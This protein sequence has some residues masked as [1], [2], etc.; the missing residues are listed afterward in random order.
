MGP[1][2]F[3]PYLSLAVRASSSPLWCHHS[4]GGAQW[5]REGSAAAGS[6][7]GSSVVG[8]ER[9]DVCKGPLIPSGQPL[10]WDREITCVRV[11]ARTTATV[12]RPK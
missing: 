3:Y 8:G 6:A 10:F 12:F 9:K 11:C 4:T 7:C 2:L 5:R 1:F